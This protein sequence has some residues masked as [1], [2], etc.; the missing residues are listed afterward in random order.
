[1]IDV[2]G[3]QVADNAVQGIL[4]RIDA[5]AAKIGTT[6]AHVWEIYIQQARVEGIR[7][8]SLLLLLLIVAAVLVRLVFFAGKRAKEIKSNGRY[9]SDGDG[10]VAICII[11][12]V[13]AGFAVG[14]GLM[15]GYGALG[16]LL[17]PQYWAFQHLAADLRN[18]I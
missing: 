6:A 18:I 10:W 11:S 8:A 13:A 16:E 17:N 1:L 4:Q 3:A 12:G 5:L 2:S 14:L 9:S 15:F 7:D